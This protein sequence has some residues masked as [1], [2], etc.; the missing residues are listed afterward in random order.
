MGIT[1]RIKY[2]FALFIHSHSYLVKSP[3][4]NNRQPYIA[5]N[6]FDNVRYDSEKK[7]DHY[8][9]TYPISSKTIHAVWIALES[10]DV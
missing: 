7:C 10:Q 9:G 8:V 1:W 3:R 4:F 2:A 6:K 5:D